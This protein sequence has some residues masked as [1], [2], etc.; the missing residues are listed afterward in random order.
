MSMLP[1]SQPASPLEELPIEIHTMILHQMASP[2][3]LSATIRAS[4]TAL[5]AFLSSRETILASVLERHI[6]PEI[7]SYYLAVLTAPDYANFNF[8]AP[9]YVSPSRCTGSPRTDKTETGTPARDMNTSPTKLTSV[10][11]FG[12]MNGRSLRIPFTNKRS[13]L[14][15]VLAQ[16]ALREASSEG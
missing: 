6:P 8:V 4:P 15:T 2:K 10:M 14:P 9:M 16:A 5:G 7:F 11:S 3:D 1:T 12:G 13:T